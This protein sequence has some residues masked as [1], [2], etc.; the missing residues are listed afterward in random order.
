MDCLHH[1]LLCIDLNLSQFFKNHTNTLQLNSKMMKRVAT[2]L[3]NKMVANTL[4]M[5]IIM[6]KVVV[7]KII[8]NILMNSNKFA[9]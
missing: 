2:N 9:R 3:N 6:N 7:M 5:K 4:K 1:L 8:V